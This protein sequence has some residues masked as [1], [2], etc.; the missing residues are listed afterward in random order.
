M[1]ITA[2]VGPQRR[3]RNARGEGSRL[4]EDIVAAALALIERAGSDEAVTLRAVAREI[5][6]AAPSIYPHFADR[7]SIVMAVVARLFDELTAAIQEGARSAG[8]D[9]VERLLAGCEQ[10][11]QYGLQHP[12]RYWVLFPGRRTES[13]RP[14][15]YCRPVSI[16][17]GGRPVLE[18]GAAAFALL[19]EAIEQC[20][21]A[22][23][24]ASTDV[25][26]DGT[27]VW[28]ALHGTVTLR[29]AAPGFPWPEPVAGFV[30]QLV[31]PLAKVTAPSA[32]T[33]GPPAAERP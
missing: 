26:A 30:R 15:D 19:V 28:V 14:A 17:P 24:S 33:A 29:T 22:G 13:V 3:Q 32:A 12:A 4:T 31:L 8:E 25:V 11:V 6:I 23:A 9:P 27:A 20:V 7:D 2:D 10:Y 5:G 16:G 18:F 21:A 1:K